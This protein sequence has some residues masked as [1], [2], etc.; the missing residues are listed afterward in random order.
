MINVGIVSSK[1]NVAFNMASV[2]CKVG[3]HCE[4]M[5][6]Y[7]FEKIK[8]CNIVV[9]DLDNLAKGED[10][11]IKQTAAGF[12][13]IVVAGFSRSQDVMDE[14]R[15]IMNVQLKPFK[16]DHILTFIED[17]K[18][19]EKDTCSVNR[20]ENPI[21]APN[22]D[23]TF[24]RDALNTDVFSNEELSLKLSKVINKHYDGP[25]EKQ[26]L[27]SIN[28]D[29]VVIPEKPAPLIVELKQPKE[30]DF[31]EEFIN[32]ALLLY[33][34]KKLRQLR[35]SP[36]EIKSRVRAL[37]MYDATH[38]NNQNKLDTEQLKTKFET[39]SKINVAIDGNGDIKRTEIK[40][41]ELKIEDQRNERIEDEVDYIE[42]PDINRNEQNNDNYNQAELK[43]IKQPA[44][45]SGTQN[46]KPIPK[47]TS[48]VP[49]ENG[50]I[51]MDK[52]EL[53]KKVQISMTPE[54]I[55]KLRKLGVKI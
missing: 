12:G 28:L 21:Y 34:A 55:E 1:E 4:R 43:Y 35:L 46:V 24:E 40:E 20:E 38:G 17:L 7:S 45:P 2:V 3:A 36:N 48:M 49:K 33:R 29:D 39:S 25:S 9:I 31:A 47:S 6:K 14:F 23:A 54:Q 18:H 13:D 30:V 32:D 37:M 51:V 41:V 19:L 16:R 53:S 10:D 27:K 5:E 22:G 42:M 26:F 15:P 8:T 52:A 50:K 44:T 11:I